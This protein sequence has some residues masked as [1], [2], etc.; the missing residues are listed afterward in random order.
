MSRQLATKNLEVSTSRAVPDWLSLNKEDFKGVVLRMPTR[1][2]IQPDRQRAGGRRILF[3]L[4]QKPPDEGAK[5]IIR[6]FSGPR[7]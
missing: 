7:E 1:D 2:D 4:N 5:T 3:P 6:A